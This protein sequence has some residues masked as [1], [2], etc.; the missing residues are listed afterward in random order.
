[1]AFPT[2]IK[3]TRYSQIKNWVG[4]IARILSSHAKFLDLQGKETSDS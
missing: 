1:M 2:R 3:H 4:P